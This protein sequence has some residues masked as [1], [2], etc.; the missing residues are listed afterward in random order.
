MSAN[1]V[2]K[3]TLTDWINLVTDITLSGIFLT[4]TLPILLIVALAI[5][6]EG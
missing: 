2:Q 5:R 3:K 4:I 1:R 6:F